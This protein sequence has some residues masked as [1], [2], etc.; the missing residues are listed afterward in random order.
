MSGGKRYDWITWVVYGIVTLFFF[1]VLLRVA[2]VL[3]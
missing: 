1:A 2:G 3:K